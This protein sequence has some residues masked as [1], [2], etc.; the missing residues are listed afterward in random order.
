MTASS[1]S[2][3]TG[4]VRSAELAEVGRSAVEPR[5]RLL[6]L[7]RQPEEGGH[8]AEPAHEL[9]PDGKT[10]T[11]PMQRNRHRRLAGHVE[12]S[13]VGNRF[14]DSLAEVLEDPHERRTD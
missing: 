13:G 4:P 10:V 12:Q 2:R 11:A 5:L 9:N 8:L 7:P 3:S 14:E 6:E 1:R